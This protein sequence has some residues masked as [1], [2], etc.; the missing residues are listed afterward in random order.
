MLL[1]IDVLMGQYGSDSISM[2]AL[3]AMAPTLSSW[4]HPS[5]MRGRSTLFAMIDPRLLPMPRPIRKTARINEN[6]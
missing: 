2:Y 5:A 6:V 3:H 1:L 4:H